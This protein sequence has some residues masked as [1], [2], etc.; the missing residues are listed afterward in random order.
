[1]GGEKRNKEDGVVMKND[2]NMDDQV[3]TGNRD[4]EKV[5]KYGLWK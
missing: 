1:M 4:G 5:R 3:E 2:A